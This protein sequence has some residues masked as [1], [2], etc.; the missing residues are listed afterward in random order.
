MIYDLGNR[1]K[2]ARLAYGMSRAELARRVGLTPA[3]IYSI[4]SGLTPDPRCSTVV[5]I[6]VT[7]KIPLTALLETEPSQIRIPGL[8]EPDDAYITTGDHS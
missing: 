8:L 1:I 4:E 7:L 6:A 5:A 2:R 3:A